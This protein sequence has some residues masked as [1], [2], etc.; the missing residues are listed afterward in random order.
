[1]NSIEI[2]KLIKSSDYQISQ[3]NVS[4]IASQTLPTKHNK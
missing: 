3:R 4:K 2:P 1:M